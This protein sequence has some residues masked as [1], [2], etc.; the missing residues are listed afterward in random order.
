MRRRTPLG[1]REPPNT[2]RDVDPL[3]NPFVVSHQPSS[4]EKQS[5]II[6]HIN[7]GRFDGKYYETVLQHKTENGSW[8]LVVC[9]S[10]YSH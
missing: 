8:Q 3:K 4:A 7:D 6:S 1:E 2:I 5:L 10:Y 9:F